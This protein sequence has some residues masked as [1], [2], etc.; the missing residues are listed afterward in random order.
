MHAFEIKQFCEWLKSV[1][2]RM[3]DQ[4]KVDK[5]N[6]SEDWTEE[7]IVP[8]AI[9]EILPYEEK[10]NWNYCNLNEIYSAEDI[11]QLFKVKPYELNKCFSK[12]F[13]K[14]SEDEIK[15]WAVFSKLIKTNLPINEILI[16]YSR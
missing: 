10:Q 5:S 14:L 16:I 3:N 9:Y 6:Y 2:K 7:V 8:E 11:F 12:R 1:N 13:Y 15:E 4:L